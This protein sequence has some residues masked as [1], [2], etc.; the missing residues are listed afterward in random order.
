MVSKAADRAVWE[1]LKDIRPP[2]Y[3]GNPIY[4]DRFLEKLDNWGMTVT[5]DMDPAAGEKY[6]FK[7][8]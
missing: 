4:L 3:D 5:A 2:M 7:Q 1:D 6:V 8:F